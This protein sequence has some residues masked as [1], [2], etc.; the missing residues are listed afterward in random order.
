M[1]G[2]PPDE[3]AGETVDVGARSR[4]RLPDILVTDERRARLGAAALAVLLAVIGV[5]WFRTA[6]DLFSPPDLVCEGCADDWFRRSQLVLALGGIVL[7]GVS[8]AY[9]VHIAA[10]GRTWR[11]RR[12]VSTAAAVAMGAWALLVIVFAWT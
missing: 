8:I 9:L 12:V 10:T 3:H 1:A 5:V 11:R 6:I 4:R 7:L 2:T